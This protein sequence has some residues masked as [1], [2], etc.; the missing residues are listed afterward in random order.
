MPALY[1]LCTKDQA[2]PLAAKERM[3]AA[4]TWA[5]AKFETPYL[6]FGHSPSLKLPELTAKVIK[7]AAKEACQ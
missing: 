4:F 3:V 2:F 5:G 6:E 7:E 1:N